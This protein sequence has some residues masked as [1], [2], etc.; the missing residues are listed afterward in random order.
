MESAIDYLA[1]F[2]G[3]R[4]IAVLAG[5][6]ELG[7]RSVDLHHGIGAYA[8]KAG[9]DVLAAI[10]EKGS[11]IAAGFVLAPGKKGKVKTYE[12]NAEAI[13][14]LYKFLAD[15]DVVLVKGS[16]AMKTEEIVDALKDGRAVKTK[17]RA[18]AL[19]NERAVNTKERAER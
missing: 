16:R 1:S 19:K 4:K 5:M 9:V 11:D 2:T 15:G 3:D 8:A 12:N 10:G 17:A 18:G 7:T 13:D 14:G 6:N